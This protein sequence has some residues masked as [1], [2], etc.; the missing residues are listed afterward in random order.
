MS[1]IFTLRTNRWVRFGFSGSIVL[2]GWGGQ[3]VSFNTTEGGESQCLKGSRT[4]TFWAN[5][6]LVFCLFRNPTKNLWR[7]GCSHAPASLRRRSSGFGNLLSTL[8]RFAAN[9]AL[10]RV[11]FFIHWALLFDWLCAENNCW[12]RNEEWVKGTKDEPFAPRVLMFFCI[13]TTIASWEDCR[14]D[15]KKGG[16]D[17]GV[18]ATEKHE[19]RR[20]W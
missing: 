3:E 13:P 8:V 18:N 4:Y 10:W 1:P 15:P 12:N 9:G 11:Y 17:D 7:E 19:F 5:A 14:C 6:S 20:L 16:I 2:V